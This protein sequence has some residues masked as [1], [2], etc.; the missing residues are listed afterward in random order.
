MNSL[1]NWFDNGIDTKKLRSIV[2]VGDG[3]VGKS[4]Y[5]ERLFLERKDYKFRKNYLATVGFNLKE[6]QLKTNKGLITI[7]LWDTA[8]QEKFGN[9]RRSYVHGADGVLIL[10]DVT[11]RST[12]DNVR[13][14]LKY[15]KENCAVPPP[16]I[17]CGNKK[18]KLNDTN[19]L[20]SALI[21]ECDLRSNYMGDNQDIGN[22]LI[23]VK[24]N[25]NV[26]KSLESLLSVV[27]KTNIKLI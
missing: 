13:K 12:K 18:D 22:M 10:Y 20:G 2:L 23:S 5:F 11:E 15:L 9:L 21:R 17:V 25:E 16:V 19:L 26:S 27:Y 1:F 3:A 8:G 7:S 6:I 24:N 4:S 14:W